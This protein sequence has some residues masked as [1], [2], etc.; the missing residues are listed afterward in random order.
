MR[1]V[2]GGGKPERPAFAEGVVT[3]GSSVGSEPLLDRAATGVV[4]RRGGVRS[5]RSRPSPGRVVPRSARVDDVVTA[6]AGQRLAGTLAIGEGSSWACV[7]V[8]RRSEGRRF[9][10]L[11]S[12]PVSFAGVG[13]GRP[14][15][16]PAPDR[17]LHLRPA[18]EEPSRRDHRGVRVREHAEGRRGRRGRPR[19]LPPRGPGRGRHRAV[20]EPLVVGTG[21]EAVQEALDVQRR[22]VSARKVVVSLVPTAVSDPR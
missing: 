1:A 16:H 21:L 10:A 8:V 2:R 7:E 9:V 19:G 3:S 4:L 14:G 15:A 20:P 11:L 17:L 22:G 18:G 6:L 13:E 12:T 5:A